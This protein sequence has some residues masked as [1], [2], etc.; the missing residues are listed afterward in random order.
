V[1]LIAVLTL[2]SG[3]DAQ[4]ANLIRGLDASECAPD[5]LVLVDIG[6]NARMPSARRFRVEV[7][8]LDAEGEPPLALARNVAAETTEAERLVFLDVDCIPAREMVAGYEAALSEFPGIVM[9]GVRYLRPGSSPRP[10]VDAALRA[11]SDP[12]PARPEPPAG[13]TPTEHYELL[14]SLSFGIGRAAW[15]RIG[16]FDPGYHG[17]GAEDTDFAFAARAAGVPLAWAGGAG[18][19]HQHHTRCRPPLDGVDAVV[20]NAHRFRIRWGEWP[21]GGW[22][23]QLAALGIVAWESDGERLEVLRR[24]TLREIER[25]RGA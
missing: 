8:R 16:G 13:V 20:R 23:A 3:R 1:G 17:Y 18:C 21:M 15:D 4:L 10:G 11:E 25:A 22:L 5:V 19:F 6:G 24:P 12:H 7:V 14:W 9:G 2:T